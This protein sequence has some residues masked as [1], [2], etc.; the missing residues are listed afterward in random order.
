MT[1]VLYLLLAALEPLRLEPR[2][3]GALTALS[4]TGPIAQAELARLLGISGATIVQIADTLEERG[5]VERRRDP[6]DP[7]DRRTQ[8]LHLRPGTPAVL[9]R[10]NTV[11]P[12]TL[13]AGLHALTAAETRRLVLLLQRFVTAP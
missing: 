12:A 11:E 3:F 8:L 2:L 1:D 5:F 10:A 4:G 7:A 13:A 6:G 9:E